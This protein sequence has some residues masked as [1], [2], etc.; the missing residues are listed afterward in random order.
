MTKYEV[1]EWLAAE[2]LDSELMEE[3]IHRLVVQEEEDSTSL[4]LMA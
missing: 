2:G 1:A 3:T 4:S